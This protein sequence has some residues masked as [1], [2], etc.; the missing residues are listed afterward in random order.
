MMMRE[1]KVRK[2]TTNDINS[3]HEIEKNSIKSAWS[4]EQL[5]TAF[6]QE[7]YHFCVCDDG[8]VLGY[9]GVKITFDECEIMNIAVKESERGKG[10][11]GELIKALVEFCQQNKVSRILLEVRESNNTA[12]TF[13]K[14]H[15]FHEIFKRKKYYSDGEDAVIMEQKL[16]SLAQ[17]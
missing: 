11:G 10:I 9:I 15:E 4:F 2:A 16:V 7:N 5:K 8:E 6:L 14:R 3:I 17:E 12:I 1:R 13:Y